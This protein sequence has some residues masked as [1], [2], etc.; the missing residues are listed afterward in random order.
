MIN[1]G[2]SHVKQAGSDN[3]LLLP[4]VLGQRRRGD[5]LDGVHRGRSQAAGQRKGAGHLAH[6]DQAGGAHRRG[7]E[8][9]GDDLAGFGWQ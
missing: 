5:H 3:A 4:E 6:R 2:W 7:L 9:D 8:Q 1:T